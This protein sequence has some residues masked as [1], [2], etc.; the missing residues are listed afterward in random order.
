[1]KPRQLNLFADKK[2]FREMNARLQKEAKEI[3]KRQKPLEE[4]LNKCKPP[5]VKETQSKREIGCGVWA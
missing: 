2:H 5:E 1:M 4:T 3:M